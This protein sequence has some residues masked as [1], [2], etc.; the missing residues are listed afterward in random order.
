MYELTFFLSILKASITVSVNQIPYDYSK[1]SMAFVDAA[2]ELKADG[3][4]LKPRLAQYNTLHGLRHSV[5]DAYLKPVFHRKN[6]KI[7]IN[8]RVHRVKLGGVS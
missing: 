4:H 5:F 3:P 1:L 6:L 7:L 2:N 8:T